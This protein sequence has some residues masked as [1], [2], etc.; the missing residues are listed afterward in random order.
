MKKP[1]RSRQWKKPRG[2]ETSANHI[3]IH[4]L[5]HQKDVSQFYYSVYTA[6]SKRGYSDITLDFST[7]QPIYPNACVPVVAAIDYYRAQGIDIEATETCHFV[8]KSCILS[9]REA[10]SETLQKTTDPV[11]KLWKFGDSEGVHTL[12][13][14]YVD[15]LSERLVCE[16]GVLEGFEWCLNEVMDNV[17]Q[18]SEAEYGYAMVQVHPGFRNVAVC[19]CDTGIGIFNSLVHSKYKP[20][21][22]TDAITLAI[23]E[24][25]TRDTSIGQGNGLWGLSQI[26]SGSN[27]S[28][29]ITSGKGSLFHKGGRINTFADLPFLSKDNLGT[30][31][32]FQLST[33]HEINIS[34]SLSY[35]HISLRV[36]A[37]ERDGGDFDFFIK[38]ESHGTGTRKAAIMTRNKVENLLQEVS[39]KIN[40]NFNDVGVISS[41][42][43]DE[44]VGKLVVQFGFFNFQKLIG[45]ENM[46]DTVQG[47]LHR[48][49]AQRMAESISPNHK[50]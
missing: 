21:T 9:P 46:N 41:S 22:H 32:D 48:S 20:R 16:K 15:S 45:L 47:I 34:E 5:N 13:S 3:K 7:A 19:I 12:T 17:L 28:L 36:E 49:I 18:H 14:M 4:S 11:S 38:E 35:D 29:A 6:T 33:D 24:G 10:N 2:L 40:L 30:T 23:K 37:Y 42:Y 43:A 44:L 8:D 39:G 26:V 31:V 1:N 27:G 50:K 25:V